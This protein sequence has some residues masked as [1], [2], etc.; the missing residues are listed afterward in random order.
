MFPL[1]Y[2][3][4]HD[5]QRG[6]LAKTVKVRHFLCFDVASS[7]YVGIYVSL[8]NFIIMEIDF[9]QGHLPRRSFNSVAECFSTWCLMPTSLKETLLVVLEVFS[10]KAFK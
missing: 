4:K 2:E 9:P 7:S 6:W 5:S 8:K 10:Y 1:I 3:P